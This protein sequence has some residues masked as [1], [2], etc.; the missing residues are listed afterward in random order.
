[1]LF[2]WHTGK[3][4]ARE[5]SF[6]VTCLLSRVDCGNAARSYAALLSSMWQ[7]VLLFLLFS[8]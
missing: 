8:R 1:M 7:A 6:K 3:S 4:G 5:D 2:F